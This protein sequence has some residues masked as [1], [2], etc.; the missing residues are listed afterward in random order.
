MNTN[1][2]WCHECGCWGRAA[3]DA[4]AEYACSACGSNFV[5]VHDHGAGANATASAGAGSDAGVDTGSI[6]AAGPSASGGANADT[7]RSLGVTLARLMMN[8]VAP[9]HAP[10]ARDGVGDV[11]VASTID[12]GNSWPNEAGAFAA[13]IIHQLLGDR[14]GGGG[15]APRTASQESIDS[16]KTVSVDSAGVDSDSIDAERPVCPVCTEAFAVGEAAKQLPCT[17]LFHEACITPWLLHHSNTCP[18]CRAPIESHCGSAGGQRS[19]QSAGAP[20]APP[21]VPAQA[22]N[23]AAASAPTPVPRIH[24]GAVDTAYEPFPAAEVS[25]RGGAGMSMTDV[26]DSYP[27]LSRNDPPS[28]RIVSLEDDTGW[29]RRESENSVNERR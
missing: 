15:A 11:A 14:E 27:A 12:L 21:A 17:H 7:S 20:A 13:D 19:R 9:P 10:A 28:M 26:A 24:T 18:V 16:I 23:S 8:M 6:H 22:L 29:E 1:Q 4:S 2:F 3:L 5:E 25:A